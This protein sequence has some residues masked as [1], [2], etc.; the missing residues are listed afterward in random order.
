MDGVSGNPDLDALFAQA[1]RRID[2][3]NRANQPNKTQGSGG[4]GGSGGDAKSGDDGKTAASGAQANESAAN[5]WNG[6]SPSPAK[7]DPAMPSSGEAKASSCDDVKAKEVSSH[8]AS[9]E[10]NDASKLTDADQGVADAMSKVRDLGKQLQDTDQGVADAA[11]TVDSAQKDFDAADQKV[12]DAMSKRADIAMKKAGDLTKQLGGADKEVAD[13]VK[14]RD[15]A[16]T[17]LAGAKKSLSDALS[18]RSDAA[19]KVGKAAQSMQ[20]ALKKENAVADSIS[21]PAA[22]AD[23]KKSAANNGPLHKPSTPAEQAQKEAEHAQQ[24]ADDAKQTAD[25]A[26]SAADAAQRTADDAKKLADDAQKK[27]DETKKN[28]TWLD[29]MLGPKPSK[30]EA[31]Q[32]AAGDAKTVANEAQATADASKK[33]ADETKKTADDAHKAAD[34]AKSKATIEKLKEALAKKPGDAAK[35]AEPK[36][37]LDKVLDAHPELKSNQDV[38]N[39]LY[40]DGGGTWDGAVKEAKKAGVTMTELVQNRQA[41]ARATAAAHRPAST[42]PANPD[43]AKPDPAKPDPA[44]P[45][46]AKPTEPTRPAGPKG[47]LK[48]NQQEA[49]QAAIREGLSPTAARALVANMTGESLAKPNDNHWDVHHM[50]QGIVQWDPQRSAAIKKQFGKEPKDMTVAEQ[51]K[52]AIW[53]MKSNPGYRQTW[54]ALQG[55]DANAMMSALVKNYERPANASRAIAQRMAAYRSLAWLN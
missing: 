1:Q 21:K 51:T 8:D 12:K 24:K 26:K 22:S 18:K 13:A 9:N 30:A 33:V 20:D 15:G 6:F 37:E 52:A 25:D 50:S 34:D 54:Q 31:A 41:D 16:A 2:D 17:K 47:S 39:K 4:A 32:K 53:E 23:T 46:P 14:A 49:Y 38:I 10:A 19:D 43:P 36:S 48:A 27:A 5:K 29:R 11:K 35:P 55:N 42:D 28:E 3:A 45:D 40:E 7:T 44:K